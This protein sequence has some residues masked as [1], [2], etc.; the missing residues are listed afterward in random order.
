MGLVVVIEAIKKPLSMQGA[1]RAK[2]P[3]QWGTSVMPR[4]LLRSARFFQL[5]GLT[6]PPLRD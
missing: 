1:L 3:F 5:L 6:I 4:R 2:D